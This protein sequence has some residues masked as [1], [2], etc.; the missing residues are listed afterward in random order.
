MEAA[1]PRARLSEDR[2]ADEELLYHRVREQYFGRDAENKP[3][4]STN[5]FN[6]KQKKPSVDR[7]NLTGFDPQRTRWEVS[8][9]VVSLLT[10]EV[11]AIT[12]IIERT[13]TGAPVAPYVIDVKPDPI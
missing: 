5:A 2:V 7:A 3:F 11:R 13:A 6:D 1:D 4:V 12:S 10:G 9:A 8:D